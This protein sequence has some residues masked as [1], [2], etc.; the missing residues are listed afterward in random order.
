[1]AKDSNGSIRTFDAMVYSPATVYMPRNAIRPSLRDDISLVT[2]SL[3]GLVWFAFL[4]LFI[5]LALPS[6]S[7]AG[8]TTIQLSNKPTAG[9]PGRD[10]RSTPPTPPFV[11]TGSGSGSAQGFPAE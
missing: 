2:I 10:F 4:V 5:G 11:T 1:M 3:D 9:C 6:I 8:L 7:N